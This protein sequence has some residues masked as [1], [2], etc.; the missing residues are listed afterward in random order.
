M[1]SI[2]LAPLFPSLGQAHRLVISSPDFNRGRFSKGEWVLQ[3]GFGIPKGA[4]KASMIGKLVAYRKGA[5]LP[6]LDLYE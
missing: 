5:I 6:M 3:W 4:T 1:K 2:P